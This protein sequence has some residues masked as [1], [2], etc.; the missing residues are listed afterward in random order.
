MQMPAKLYSLP[1]WAK[2]KKKNQFNIVNKNLNY[3]ST[4]P[5][6][7]SVFHIIN[8]QRKKQYFLFKKI[9]KFWFKKCKS[10]TKLYKNSLLFSHHNKFLKQYYYS[11][12]RTSKKFFR[13]NNKIKKKRQKKQERTFKK[14]INLV[15]GSQKTQKISRIKKYKFKKIFNKYFQKKNH[16]STKSKIKNRKKKLQFLY[17]RSKKIK[18]KIYRRLRKY[19]LRYKY[20]TA[21]NKKHT[22]SRNLRL[23][24]KVY[25]L[26]R[27]PR[28][29]KLTWKERMLEKENWRK[30]TRK[31]KIKAMLTSRRN[32]IKDW[33]QKWRE[34]YKKRDRILWA[35]FLFRG[36]RAVNIRKWQK[37][38]STYHKWYLSFRNKEKNFQFRESRYIPHKWLFQRGIWQ[39]FSPLRR[40]KLLRFED[41]HT[42]R[43]LFRFHPNL[44]SKLSRQKKNCIAYRRQIRLKIRYW[45]KNWNKRY[46]HFKYKRF[47][48]NQHRFRQ[49]RSFQ[50]RH[51]R[52]FLTYRAQYILSNF[53]YKYTNTISSNT[54]IPIPTIKKSNPKLTTNWYYSQYRSLW[55]ANSK[56]N[57]FKAISITKFPFANTQYYNKFIINIL[58]NTLVS[59]INLFNNYNTIYKNNYFKNKFNKQLIKNLILTR[60]KFYKINIHFTQKKILRHLAIFSSVH[61][62]YFKKIIEGRYKWWYES[63]F[64]RIKLFRKRFKRWF[65][66]YRKIKKHHLFSSVFRSNFYWLTGF[67]EQSLLELWA[68]YRR[69]TNNHWGIGSGLVQR[70]SQ[71]LLL[72]PSNILLFLHFA[73]T[74][75]SAN[76]LIKS[77]NIIINGKQIT[78][79]YYG[80]KVGDIV[81]LNIQFFKFNNY[82]YN[83]QR[84][85]CYNYLKLNYISFLYVDLSILMFILIS[86]PQSFE[87]IAPK[88]LSERWIR[89]YIRHFPV[90]LKYFKN[91]KFNWVEDFKK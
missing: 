68:K 91:A 42:F 83:Y 37:R 34:I 12:H 39:E 74:I 18:N 46:W 48:R 63:K 84:K 73:P 75:S 43:I 89:Y 87:F 7:P 29:K 45:K 65:G 62:K 35:K 11:I 20:T 49:N 3:N 52:T 30:K 44:W 85:Q 69:G 4:V 31:Q 88:F 24:T 86:I 60:S 17:N 27:F 76:S 57:F 66:R 56:I 1:T 67:H 55:T 5:H 71:S 22:V 61:Q 21:K 6:W 58:L 90:K 2:K 33:K 81:Q 26:Y 50:K 79:I 40:I 54:Q 64:Y 32:I 19:Y 16:F 53:Q 9:K 23:L 10:N 15:Q 78:N 77:G 25:Y 80:L 72:S 28:Q 8:K 14:M 41:D 38:R 13:K 36:R 51:Y 59:N 70:F 82:L 47:V